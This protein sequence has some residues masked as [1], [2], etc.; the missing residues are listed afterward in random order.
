[1]QIVSMRLPL[2][3]G[4]GT[5]YHA[6]PTVP[7]DAMLWWVAL[8]PVVSSWVSSNLALRLQ[9]RKLLLRKTILATTPTF[10]DGTDHQPKYGGMASSHSR[11]LIW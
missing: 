5:D 9:N 6:E 1:V 11:Q 2:L 7:C 8:A 10:N 4:I 3:R